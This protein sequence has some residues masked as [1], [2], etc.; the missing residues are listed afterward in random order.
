MST[1][2]LVD[3]GNDREMIKDIS[4]WLSKE[5]QMDAHKSFVQIVKLFTKTAIDNGYMTKRELISGLC[6][7]SEEL[8]ALAEDEEETEEILGGL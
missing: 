4:R 7:S 1:K 2:H 5:R 8:L 6:L 3:F